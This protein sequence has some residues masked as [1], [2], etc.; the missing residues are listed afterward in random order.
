[1]PLPALHLLQVSDQA[2]MRIPKI[3]T[4]GQWRKECSAKE[5]N[6]NASTEANVI[7]EKASLGMK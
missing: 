4:Y 5:K 6:H 1:M 7:E 2:I 3:I